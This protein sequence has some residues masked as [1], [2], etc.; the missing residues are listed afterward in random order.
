MHASERGEGMM[1]ALCERACG[2]WLVHSP[3]VSQRHPSVPVPFYAAVIVCALRRAVR[4]VMQ[5]HPHQYAMR[6]GGD[7][8]EFV[9]CRSFAC[10]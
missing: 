1:S 2:A 10:A 5:P 8:L 7:I 4:V 9:A 3:G 6:W